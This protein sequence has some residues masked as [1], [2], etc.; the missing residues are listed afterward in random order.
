MSLDIYFLDPSTLDYLDIEGNTNITHN[1]NVI[2]EELGFYEILWRPD[3]TIGLF[4]DPS[5]IVASEILPYYLKAFLTVL[6]K[7]DDSIKHLLPSNGWGTLECFHRVLS[8]CIFMCTKYPNAIIR[9][10][11]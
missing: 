7:G 6:E 10:S 5:K 8:T 2:A 11:T 1:L 4:K 9:T 3:E